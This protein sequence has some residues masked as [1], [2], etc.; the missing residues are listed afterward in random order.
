MSKET[1]NEKIKKI[2]DLP[3][4]QKV[5]QTRKNAK[6]PILKEEERIISILKQMNSQGKL[7]E[8][9]MKKLQP[10]GSQPPRLY[11]L[12]KIHKDDVPLRPVL[13]MPGSPY[14]KIALQISEW[15]SVVEE[16]KINSSTKE[17]SDSLQDIRLPIDHVLVSFDVTSLYTNVPVLEAIENCTD[18]LY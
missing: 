8:S 12:A 3:Q 4:F 15:L 14:H 18:L 13:S 2:T 17:I 6:N 5:E 11:G 16:C 9:L 7:D 1:Y 10:S